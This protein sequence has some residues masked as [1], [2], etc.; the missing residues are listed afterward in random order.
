MT[1]FAPQNMINTAFSLLT[2][3]AI[4]LKFYSMIEKIV[5]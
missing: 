1:P 2:V 4:S 3:I 5:T